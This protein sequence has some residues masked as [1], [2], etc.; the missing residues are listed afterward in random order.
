MAEGKE[1]NDRIPSFTASDFRAATLTPL[2]EL[3]VFITIFV[4]ILLMFDFKIFCLFLV[5]FSE[6]FCKKCRKSIFI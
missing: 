3:K 2:E 6:K 4:N 1:F 5:L